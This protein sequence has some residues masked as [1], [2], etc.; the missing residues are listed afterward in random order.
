MPSMSGDSERHSLEREACQEGQKQIPTDLNSPKRSPEERVTFSR[1]ISIRPHSFNHERGVPFHVSGWAGNLA[2]R[3]CAIQPLVYAFL[4]RVARSQVR[5]GQDEKKA[6]NSYVEGK[7]REILF[8]SIFC[9]LLS[10]FLACGSL[11]SIFSSP[12]RSN[13]LQLFC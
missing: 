4:P 9:F 5:S 12:E 10:I 1:K 6:M 3:V 7:G 11:S 8:F 2:T 13:D